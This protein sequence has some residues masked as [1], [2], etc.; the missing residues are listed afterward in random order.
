MFPKT[1]SALISLEGLHEPLL[2]G[3]VEQLLA[4]KQL[5][6]K[7]FAWSINGYTRR[8]DST[9]NFRATPRGDA[10]QLDL[11]D[12]LSYQRKQIPHTVE[13]IR[14]VLLKIYRVKGSTTLR[15][16]HNYIAG[17]MYLT[18]Q[19]EMITNEDLDTTQYSFPLLAEYLVNFTN[20][21]LERML[22]F[23]CN[24][25]LEIKTCRSDNRDE[26]YQ[27]TWT[28]RTPL[29]KPLAEHLHD[30]QR[31]E[32]VRRQGIPPDFTI[33]VGELDDPEALVRFPCHRV[34]LNTWGGD[35]FRAL[36]RIG[37]VEG[38]SRSVHI[39]DVNP[40]TVQFFL[41]GLYLGPEQLNRCGSSVD[42]VDLFD[43][44]SFACSYQ[45]PWLQDFC[46]NELKERVDTLPDELIRELL[47]RF[48]GWPGL[49]RL[50]KGAPGK[51]IQITKESHRPPSKS[52]YYVSTITPPI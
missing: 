20:V 19:G 6:I 18:Y 26:S 16:V 50:F 43:L 22:R 38:A 39:R 48:S 28:W 37:M 3:Q 24:S 52:L 12:S 14:Q 7:L 8:I 11:P 51:V 4:D 31:F 33:I 13:V 2:F 40:S 17:G 5:F 36:L 27:F 34:M 10:V 45:I 46:L 29:L 23:L 15:V 30:H 1:G 21:I 44:I 9:T 47:D 32:I 35:G 25:D 42:E 41:D 49:K